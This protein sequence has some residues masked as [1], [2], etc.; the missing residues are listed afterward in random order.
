MQDLR[1]IF[2]FINLIIHHNIAYPMPHTKQQQQSINSQIMKSKKKY[3]EIQ[4][5]NGDKVEQYTK[6]TK[7]QKL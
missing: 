1:F 3:K 7:L 5:R 6:F 2:H 4:E